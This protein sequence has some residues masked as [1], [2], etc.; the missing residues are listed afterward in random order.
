M[1]MLSTLL[2]LVGV[3][4][5][6]SAAHAQSE[7]PYRVVVNAA[8]P[9]SSLT[10]E[11]VSR[12]FLKK[13]T[14]WNDGKGVALVDQAEDASVRRVFTKTVHGREISSVKS[15]WQQMIFSGRAVP[16]PEKATDADVI[17]FVSSNVNAI[18]Y[19]SASAPIATGVKAIP[20]V[21]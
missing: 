5:G 10:R 11:Q 9:V 15:Y 12:L 14:R 20:I 16:P 18:G 8:N 2:I 3:L 7:A 17:S 21:N 19:V 6:S 4:A 1:R 13:V